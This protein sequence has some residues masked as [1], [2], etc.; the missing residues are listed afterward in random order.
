MQII[1]EQDQFVWSIRR[2]INTP[3]DCSLFQ[4]IH[5]YAEVAEV[6]FEHRGLSRAFLNEEV[7]LKMHPIIQKWSETDKYDAQNIILHQNIIQNKILADKLT[8]WHHIPKVY[9]SKTN[10]PAFIL[11][12]NA[13][14]LY[15]SEDYF[16]C[17]AHANKTDGGESTYQKLSDAFDILNKESILFK[18]VKISGAQNTSP[19]QRNIGREYTD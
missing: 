4:T 1:N 16:I 17:C 18:T 19:L 11:F 2:K 14:M 3:T 8:A 13:Y 15:H 10:C 7:F 9:P 6:F 5:R 12:D